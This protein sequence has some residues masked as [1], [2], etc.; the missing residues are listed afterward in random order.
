MKKNVNQLKIG[1]ILSIKCGHSVCLNKFE[2]MSERYL[3][4]RGR[5]I[6]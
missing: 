5:I 2:R 1:V 6:L 4:I 3:E